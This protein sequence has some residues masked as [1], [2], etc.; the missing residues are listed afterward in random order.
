MGFPNTIPYPLELPIT[1]SAYSLEMIS[2]TNIQQ[3]VYTQR[4]YVS[5]SPA[6][7]MWGLTLTFP[8]IVEPRIAASVGAFS[9]GLRGRLGTFVFNIPERDLNFNETDDVIF[10]AIVNDT[11]NKIEVADL[12]AGLQI[13]TYITLEDQ[14]LKVIDIDTDLKHLTIFPSIR[15]TPNLDTVIQH[16][17]GL[18]YG[19]FRLKNNSSTIGFDNNHIYTYSIDALESTKL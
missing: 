10:K 5:F 6:G 14:L 4:Q 18:V 11:R 12:N 16:T 2:V 19:Y 9:S 3:S 8:P 1:P 15:T 13:G 7:Q 17:P